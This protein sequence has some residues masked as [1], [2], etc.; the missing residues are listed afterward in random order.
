MDEFE[1]LRTFQ[2]DLQSAL[3]AAYD[4]KLSESDQQYVFTQALHRAQAR[5]PAVDNCEESR[6]YIVTH[7]NLHRAYDLAGIKW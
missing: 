1:D 4:P 6:C 3:N 5:H 7:N 2:K